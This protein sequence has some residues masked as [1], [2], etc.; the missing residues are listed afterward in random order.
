MKRFTSK[1]LAAAILAA[2]ISGSGIATAQEKV[3]MLDE[4]VVT[5]RQKAET[6]Q[7]V[8]LSVHALTA[9]QIE[10]QGILRL[11]DIVRSAPGVA[12]NSS[13]SIATTAVVIR[14]MD[15]PGGIGQDTNVAVFVDGVYISGRDAAYMPMMGMERVEVVRGPQSA[16][17]GRNAFAGAINYI[18]KKPGEEFE[19]QI[20]ATAGGEGQKG[21]KARFAGQLAENFFASIDAEDSESGSTHKQDGDYL[22]QLENE[23][24]RARFVWEATDNL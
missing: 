6:L 12:I 1:P 5:A 13:G 20:E 19:G 21:I 3:L 17:Y 18:T 8:P 11:S 14:G 16:L 9:R 24:V 22:G 4:I 2:G 7:E 23:S 15:Q 10:K